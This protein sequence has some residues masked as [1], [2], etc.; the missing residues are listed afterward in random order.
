MITTEGFN[1][2]LKIVEEPPEHLIFIFATTEPEKLLATIRSRTHNYPFRLLTPPDMRGL[3]GRIVADEGAVV[4]D[5]V[6]PLVVR[7]GG[8]RRVTRCRLWIS[9]LPV[10]VRRA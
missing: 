10:R 8:V 2:L 4:E 6:Y 9:C 5:A 7:A 3:L 1:T